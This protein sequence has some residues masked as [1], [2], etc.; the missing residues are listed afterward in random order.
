MRPT[1]LVVGPLANASANNI[2]QSQQPTAAL[3]LNGSTVVAGVAILDTPRRVLLT[4]GGDESGKTF[5]I[6][7]TDA[8]GMPQTELLAGVVSGT[9]QSA[10]DFKTV[11]SI[12]ISSA[13]AAALTFGTN[14]VA[15]SRWM[16][17]DD[18][19]MASIGLQCVTSGTVNYTV[20]QTF[21]DPDS[22]TDP[23]APYLVYWSN[24]AD[25][26][27]VGATGPIVSSFS[28]APL[29]AKVTL[30]SGSGTVT[31]NMVQY[32]DANY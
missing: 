27:A 25:S 21:Q 20:Q 31:T 4:V 29:W 23:V 22:P 18:Y 13:A 28:T 26:A 14:G 6:V 10:L 5:T 19:A 17:M 7:G 8:S 11:T 30:N 9:A 32:S 15:S 12:T 1:T 24:S 2:A 16:R 3:T